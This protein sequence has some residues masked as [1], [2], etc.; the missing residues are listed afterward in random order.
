M[1]QTIKDSVRRAMAD[2]Y[3]SFE[4]ILK[5]VNNPEW[6]GVE[7][8]HPTPDEVTS[9]LVELINDGDAQGYVLSPNE[10]HVTKAAYSEERLYELWYYLT[11][12]GIA[13]VK[14]QNEEFREG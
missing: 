5:G 11:K 12:Q 9:A 3:E 8:V 1:K 6:V 7:G 10:P 14:K 4:L 2:D 13:I